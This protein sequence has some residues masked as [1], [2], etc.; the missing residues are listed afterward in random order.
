MEDVDLD[1]PE[2]LDEINLPFDD[3]DDLFQD[4]GIRQRNL[5]PLNQSEPEGE[6]EEGEQPI[7]PNRS[8]LPLNLLPFALGGGALISNTLN[9]PPT[10]PTLRGGP[11]NP[12]QAPPLPAQPPAPGPSDP[13][14]PIPPWDSHPQLPPP[15]PVDQWNPPLEADSAGS[16][17][18][19][20]VRET[21]IPTTIP[22][23]PAFATGL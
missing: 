3:E 8:R 15:L 21:R 14:I 1:G 12:P 5:P 4:T 19:V 23:L 2:G 10:Y 11:S 16:A 17:P 18:L 13:T 20:I 22:T 6:E 9:Q 7:R